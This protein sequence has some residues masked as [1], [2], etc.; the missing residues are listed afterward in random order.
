MP[1]PTECRGDTAWISLTCFS[2]QQSNHARTWT[3]AGRWQ[4]LPAELANAFDLVVVGPAGWAPA[5]TRARLQANARGVR[6]LG[7]V[8][9]ADLPALTAVP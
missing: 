8:P 6:H 2:S 9:E 3:A 4:Q 5:E 1:S 7:Y